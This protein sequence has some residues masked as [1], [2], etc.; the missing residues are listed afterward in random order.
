VTRPYGAHCDIGAY[1]YNV[2]AYIVEQANFSSVAAYD[3]WILESNET[4]NSGGS[5]NTNSMTFSLGDDNQ[6]RQYRLILHFDTSSLPDNAVIT[7]AKLRLS[8][9]GNVSGS[10]PFSTH[11]KVVIELNTGP[12][13]GSTALQLNDFKIPSDRNGAGAVRDNLINGFYRGRIKGAALD[14][15]NLTGPTQIRL[16]FKLD[17]DDDSIADLVEFFSG[18][19]ASNSDRPRLV[20]Y[21]YI[22]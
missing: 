20:I 1:E 19:A 16:R 21:Y 17:D 9:N 2:P 5:L 15:F 3:G 4:S 22:P 11:D 14:F 12:Y 6:D 18:D 13:S 8:T 10:N 7:D